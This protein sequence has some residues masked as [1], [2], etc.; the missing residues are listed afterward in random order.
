MPEPSRVAGLAAVAVLASFAG[1]VASTT[2]H[3]APAVPLATVPF[4]PDT[5]SLAVRCGVLIDGV[6]AEPRR[7]VTVVIERGRFTTVAAGARP[8]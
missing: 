7:D 6:S 1:F 4:E 3:S 5:G 2:A 8:S